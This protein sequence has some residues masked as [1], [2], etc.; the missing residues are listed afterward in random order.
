MARTTSPCGK[1]QSPDSIPNH[2]LEVLFQWAFPL[3]IEQRLDT[4]K[5]NINLWVF[6]VSQNEG[7]VSYLNN[8]TTNHFDKTSQEE[9]EACYMAKVFLLK[10]IFAS[11]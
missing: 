3:P 10:K 4:H 9:W 7:F 11:D 8:G 5:I 1:I 6:Y 2:S